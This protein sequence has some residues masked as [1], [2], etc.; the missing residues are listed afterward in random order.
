MD[1]GYPAGSLACIKTFD[2]DRLSCFRF[3]LSANSITYKGSQLLGFFA[4]PLTADCIGAA[5]A[6]EDLLIKRD[7][8]DSEQL[9]PHCV[10]REPFEKALRP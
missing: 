3:E 5:E 8:L 6:V 7:G 10:F 1:T 9:Y 2:Q 4:H